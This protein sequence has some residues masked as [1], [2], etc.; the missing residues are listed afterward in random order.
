MDRRVLSG[1]AK[2]KLKKQKDLREAEILSQVPSI[3]SFFKNATSEYDGHIGQDRCDVVMPGSSSD[4]V[5]LTDVMEEE[6]EGNESDSEHTSEAIARGSDD[7]RQPDSSSNSEAEVEV[8]N[9]TGEDQS[10]ASSTSI[11]RVCQLTGVNT[12]DE[13]GASPWFDTV[14][15]PACWGDTQSDEAKTVL[16]ERGVKVFQN[17]RASYPASARDSGMGGK[18]RVLTNDQLKC[19]L[20]NGQVVDREWVTYSP[21]TGSIYCYACKLFS[22][23]SHSFVSGFSDWKHPERIGQHERSAEHLACVLALRHRTTAAATVDS[24][25]R[26]QIE[27]ERQYWREVLKRVVSVIKFLGERGLAFRGHDE[28]LGSPHNG[29]YLGTLELLAQFDSF[30]AEHIRKFGQKGRGSVSYLSSTICDEFIELMGRKTRQTIMKELRDAKYFSVIV[31]STPDLS[32]VDQLTYIFRFVSE[33]RIVERFVGFEP[34]SSH[35]GESL[36]DCV[37]SMVHQLGLDLGNCRGQSYDNASNMSGKYNGLQAHLKKQNPMIR[38]VPCAAHSLN[39]VGVNSIEDCSDDV[40]N[41]FDFIQSLYNFAAASTHRWANIFGDDRSQLTLKALSNT[42]WSCRAESA[43]ALW[44]HYNQLHEK[45]KHISMDVDEKR[46]TRSEARALCKKFQ[47]LEI[48]FMAKFWDTLLSR[49]HAT[50]TVL[51]RSDLSL[52]CAVRSLESL[53]DFV[54]A[55][56]D[57]FDEYE[58]AAMSVP[59]VNDAYKRDMMRQRKR[60][61]FFDETSEESVELGGKRRFQV[62]TFNVAIDR[63]VQSLRHRLEAYKEVYGLFSAL[64]AEKSE[65][66]ASF[67]QLPIHLIWINA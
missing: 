1:A 58:R 41:Y 3:F 18:T 32:H 64:Y 33:G 46:E 43:K 66:D 42:R 25:V 30:L 67:W 49:F 55:Q 45:L 63:L 16:I 37:I 28:L 27:G 24:G 10:Q 56:R 52:D 59:G 50:S 6:E 23:K 61:T 15:D 39:L 31:D 47:S 5:M 21:S 34:I 62:E 26:M 17:R 9:M 38:Y 53:C 19:T 54:S 8:R 20:P 51:Q 65:S 48:A 14:T 4:D 29:N 60:K 57:L 12:G 22:C 2:R 36:A 7:E 44:Q 13:Q 40:G 35:R 11:D